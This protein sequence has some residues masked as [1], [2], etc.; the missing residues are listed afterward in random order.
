[1]RT[2]F[3]DV[4]NWRQNS[5][6]IILTAITLPVTQTDMNI[7]AYTEPHTDIYFMVVNQL[8]LTSMN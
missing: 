5:Y 7:A 2:F 3:T 1:M 6:P 4:K 8:A